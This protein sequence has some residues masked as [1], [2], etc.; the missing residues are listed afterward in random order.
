ML[1]PGA[2]SELFVA[3]ADYAGARGIKGP[4]LL[5]FDG[6]E[7]LQCKLN[8]TPDEKE[9]IP[10]YACAILCRGWPESN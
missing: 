1:E 10:P 8:A 9:S 5:E 3:I 7:G 2:I 6:P 4:G